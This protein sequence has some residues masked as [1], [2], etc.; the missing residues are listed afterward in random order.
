MNCCL[1]TSVPLSRRT[2]R[3]RRELRRLHKKSSC[4]YWLVFSAPIPDGETMFAI[5]WHTRSRSGLPTSTAE[6]EAG[7]CT[8]TPYTVR[9]LSQRSLVPRGGGS[10]DLRGKS[11]LLVGG[12]S[13]GSELALR[14]TS[15]GVGRLTVSDPDKL[16]EENLYRHVLSVEGHR[17]TQDR[18]AGG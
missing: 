11:V 17:T 1:G 12:G 7:G 14:L 16:S 6:T 8:V 18:G 4:D 10:L 9:S 3:G 5:H 2:S 13:V 15:A